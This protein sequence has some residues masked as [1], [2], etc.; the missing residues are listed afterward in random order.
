[1]SRRRLGPGALAAFGLRCLL[2]GAAYGS[3]SAPAH[4]DDWPQW[5]GIHRDGRWHEDGVM[6][7]FPAEQLPAKWSVPIQSGYSGPTVANGRVFVTDRTL[8]PKPMERIVCLAEDTGAV[9]WTVEYP[10]EYT[11]SYTAG[12]RASVT[13]DGD[14]AYAL[15]AMGNCHCLDVR[16]GR[17]IW[18][19]DLASEYEVAMPIWGL[20]AAPLIYDDLCILVVGGTKGHSCVVALDKITGKQ[21]WQAL[22]DRAQYSAPIVIKQAGHDVLVCWTGDSVAGLN[23][24]SGE[25]HWRFPFRPQKMP[26]GIAT[27]IVEGD[28]LFVTSFYD[29]SLMLQLQPDKLD[30]EPVWQACGPS[31]RQTEALQSIIST[32]I[33]KNG[34]LFG[35]DSY[36]ELR[37]LEPATGERLWEDQTATPRARWS[38]IH[39]VENGDRIWMFN[40]R[41]EL[42]IASLDREG[43]HEHSRAK[44]IEP[45]QEQLRQRGGVCW[46]H[47]AFANRHVFI[48]NDQRILC[49]SLAAPEEN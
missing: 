16:D 3:L 18:A 27:P 1:M 10:C 31:E 43:F 17:V 20:S 47:P 41:G 36:G 7:Q 25:V 6:Q 48:R 28:R 37:C 49:A 5:R 39:F 4:A 32:P 11:I 15:G 24:R 8:T 21:L 42:I 33:F 14:R 19:A 45:T 9:N 2:V 38:N 40:E 12:P 44:L 23:P 29:G 35:C 22:D 34:L 13:I 26:I 46:A 30:V